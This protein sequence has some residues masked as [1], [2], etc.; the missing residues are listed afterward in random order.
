MT[1]LSEFRD[2]EDQY[3]FKI[4]FYNLQVPP[5]I[6]YYLLEERIPFG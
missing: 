4:K 3:K 5:Y 2:V 1:C 6:R